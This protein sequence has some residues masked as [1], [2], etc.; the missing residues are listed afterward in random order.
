M[1]KLKRAGFLFAALSAIIE[2]GKAIIKFITYIGKLRQRP[3]H[4]MV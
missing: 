4:R 3:K 1:E 2:I